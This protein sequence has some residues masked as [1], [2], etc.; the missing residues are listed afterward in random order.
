MP[1]STFQFQGKE[2]SFAPERDVG[3]SE[4]RHIKQWFPGSG[5]GTYNGL[6]A[7][8]A[9]GDPDA[10]ACV[11]WVAMKKAGVKNLRDPKSLPDF[12]V[13]E[14]M[15]SFVSQ[16]GFPP[17]P[18][19]SCR[20]TLDGEEYTFDFE[21]F[22][23]C[24]TLRKIKGWYPEIGNL[25][26]FTVAVFAGDPEAMACIAWILWTEAGKEDVPDPHFIDF[27]VG[28]VLNSYVLEI[29]EELETEPPILENP[30]TGEVK[31]VDPLL[32][33]SGTKSLA[34]IPMTSGGNTNLKSP[35]SSI[36][37]QTKLSPD[38]SSITPDGS[39]I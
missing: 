12:S 6:T 10:L 37:D 13:G 23:T 9:M 7:S 15:G 2:Y 38:L 16:A 1:E 3:I 22:L 5:L 18:V 30:I 34:V 33:P 26:R 14:L 39:S 31:P 28:E 32:P 36:S 24:K 20:L 4:L 25:V 35:S 21:K 8:T 29:P 11:V 27:A 19:P 17:E